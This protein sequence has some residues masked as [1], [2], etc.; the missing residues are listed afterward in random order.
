[1]TSYLKQPPVNGIFTA[2]HKVLQ[3]MFLLDLPHDNKLAEPG[4]LH[5]WILECSPK[6]RYNTV[7]N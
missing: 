4:R 1:M 3:L 5:I 2:S 6:K 7:G